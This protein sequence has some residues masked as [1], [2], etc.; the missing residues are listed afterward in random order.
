VNVKPE[1]RSLNKVQ[2]RPVVP[3]VGQFDFLEDIGADCRGTGPNF[4]I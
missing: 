3:K 4:R 2:F 1:Q